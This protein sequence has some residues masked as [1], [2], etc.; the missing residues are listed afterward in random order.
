M[1]TNFVLFCLGR[2]ITR[3]LVSHLRIFMVNNIKM[4]SVIINKS[5]KNEYFL[6][7]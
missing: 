3:Y 2:K 6:K 4:L 7:H 5:K 1:N